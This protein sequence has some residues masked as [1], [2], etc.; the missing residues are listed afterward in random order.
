MSSNV[1]KPHITLLQKLPAALLPW[2]QTHKRVLPWRENTDPYR[3]WVS[4]IMLQQTRVDTVIP[5]YL[6]FL[7]EL[8]TIESL[9]NAEEEKLLKL[10][11]GLGY[12]SRVRNMQRAAR[13]ICQ[14]F[15][16][17]FPSNP[18]EVGTLVG[19]GPYTVGA[20]CSIAFEAAT[21]AVDGNVLRVISRIDENSSNIAETAYKKAVTEA[22]QQVYPEPGRRGDFTQS[23]MELGAT[24]CLPNGAPKCLDCPAKEFCK[25]NQHGSWQQYPVLAKK[26][27][28]KVQHMAVFLLL[29]EDCIA[30]CKRNETGL[31]AGMWQ[32]PNTPQKAGEKTVS[33][34]LEKHKIIEKPI[35]K[36]KVAKHVFTHIE[37]Q[38]NCYTLHCKTKYSDFYWASRAELGSSVAM[39]S[40]FKKLLKEI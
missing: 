14:D 37:W 30:V 2:Y 40:A 12:Y 38:M 22:L 23:L 39:P 1:Q 33:A 19:I 3:I 36:P 32:L 25:A 31:L 16:G 4:E 11:E 29:C 34:W 28:R 6:R 17:V 7:K 24:V 13:Q 10:W 26:P 15:G 9:A 35:G 18:K 21:P 27:Q 5:Y 8:P 20:I